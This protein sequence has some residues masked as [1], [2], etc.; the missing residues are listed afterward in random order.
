MALHRSV[1]RAAFGV[2]LA[3]PAC[4]RGCN[5][6]V[7]PP[8]PVARSAVSA[9][10][11]RKPSHPADPVE[12][13]IRVR[14]PERATSGL[15]PAMRSLPWRKLPS[16]DPGAVL[17][18]V[19]RADRVDCPVLGLSTTAVDDDVKLTAL[20]R[21]ARAAWEKRSG[22]AAQR[23]LLVGAPDA[24]S[25][26]VGRVRRLLHTAGAWRVV[27]LARDGA[28]LVEILLDPPPAAR[29]QP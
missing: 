9:A 21:L 12:A 8:V 27:A 13:A 14:L 10:G 28:A 26:A 5:E 22:V 16:L 25:A 15:V 1:A 29:P 4:A 17:I 24:S 19:V 18:V 6:A 7:P 2:V 11:L 3:L 20:L 23:A